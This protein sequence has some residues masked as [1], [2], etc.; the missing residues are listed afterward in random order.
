ME[1]RNNSIIKVDLAF[2]K[3][4]KNFTRKNIVQ[5]LITISEYLC[6]QPPANNIEK[7][8]SSNVGIEGKKFITVCILRLYKIENFSLD[9]L[10][11]KKFK[12]YSLFNEILDEKIAKSLKITKKKEQSGTDH[13]KNRNSFF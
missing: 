13:D 8:I 11:D 2:K 9:S 3:L 7:L 10:T 12:I 4:E 6:L 5:Y 1:N